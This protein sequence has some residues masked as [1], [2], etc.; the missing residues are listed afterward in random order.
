MNS[1]GEVIG[2]N[3][4]RCKKDT[5]EIQLEHTF[6]V[7][8]SQS[9]LRGKGVLLDYGPYQGMLSPWKTMVDEVRFIGSNSR[10]EDGE[11]CSILIGMGSIGWSGGFLNSQPFCL[12]RVSHEFQ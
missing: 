5:T 8:I 4:F 7:K 10:D 3:R 12:A 1:S 9:K 2:S 11:D 6:G